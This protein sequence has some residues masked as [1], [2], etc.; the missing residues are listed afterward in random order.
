MSDVRSVLLGDGPS[1]V[2]VVSVLRSVP[3]DSPVLGL[4]DSVSVV[5]V[6]GIVVGLVMGVSPVDDSSVSV[7]SL[8][9]GAKTSGASVIAG[10]ALS[11]SELLGG[12]LERGGGDDGEGASEE[13]GSS[14]VHYL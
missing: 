7:G 8:L 10:V 6:V 2:G 11:L 9:G 3:G 4:S 5:R 14:E 13:K 12:L 1:F